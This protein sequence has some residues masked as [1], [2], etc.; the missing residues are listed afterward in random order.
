[1]EGSSYRSANP[2]FICLSLKPIIQQAVTYL[3]QIF[4]SFNLLDTK[5]Q[6]S[7]NKFSA[8]QEYSCSLRHV[9][10]EQASHF[11]AM[12]YSGDA[13]YPHTCKNTPETST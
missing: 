11:T 9:L 6:H 7:Q 8:R 13:K 3:P 4:I 2:I 10:Q 12:P 1:M 5:T